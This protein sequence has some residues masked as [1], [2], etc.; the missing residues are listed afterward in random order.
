MK[1]VFDQD[2]IIAEWAKDKYK[3]GL[4]P[5]WHC[6]GIVDRASQIVGA[7]SLH[8]YNGSNVELCYWGPRTLT[9]SVA[10]AIAVFCFG[11]MGVNRVTCRTPRSNKIVA[12]HL[13]KLGFKVEGLARRFYGPLKRDD[14]ILFGLT[15]DD[16]QR[17]LRR[18]K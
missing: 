1:L 18:A 7:A 17:L 16:A 2:A 15:V 4:D 10:S 6:I 14:A 3:A 13:P 9:P 12:R 11:I 8:Y 5:W